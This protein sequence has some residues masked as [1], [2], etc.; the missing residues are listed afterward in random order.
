[1]NKDRQLLT[2]NVNK[3]PTTCI[4]H[5]D[6]VHNFIYDCRLKGQPIQCVKLRPQHYQMYAFWTASIF[7]RDAVY[8]ERNEVAA[9][10]SVDGI[11]IE[12]GSGNQFAYILP[13]YLPKDEK[14]AEKYRDFRDIHG[15]LPE[16]HSQIN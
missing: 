5:I 10:I 9:P 8:N 13:V 2:A 4:R 14:R 15:V 7:G 12:E 11:G 6:E 16:H 1:M 3:L